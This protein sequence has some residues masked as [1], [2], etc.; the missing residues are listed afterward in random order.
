MTTDGI[1][2]VD[3]GIGNLLSV[4]RA[5]DACSQKA[6]VSSDPSVVR[7]ANRL[8]LPG[9][10]AFANGITSLESL[11]LVE[12][13]KD[14]IASDKPLLG[15]CLGMQLLLDTSTEH[16]YS[17]GLRVIPG[18]VNPLPSVSAKGVAVK[19]PH[20][21]W[22]K[23]AITPLR[24]LTKRDIGRIVPRDP[25]YFVHSYM[26]VPSDR[27]NIVAECSYG[28]NTIPAVISKGNVVGCQFHP[29]KSGIAGLKFIEA[30]LSL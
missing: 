21:G 3:Y 27:A 23:L 24:D 16:G 2:I 4:Q 25:V 11:C 10:G 30:W 6:V 13:I 8:I 9:V 22:N 7:S 20:I 12:A 14:F 19:I 1:V 18:S 5:V 26:V 28:G 29:E 15:I 17:E